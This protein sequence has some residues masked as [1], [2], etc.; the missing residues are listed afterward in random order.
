MAASI[1]YLRCDIVGTK[2]IRANC[3]LDG[4]V[5][6][7]WNIDVSEEETTQDSMHGQGPRHQQHEQMCILAADDA[8]L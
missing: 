5:V 6:V 4:L 1:A 3:H 7:G 2:L 8:Y